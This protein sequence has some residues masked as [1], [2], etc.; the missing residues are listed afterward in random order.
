MSQHTLGDATK[1]RR[2]FVVGYDRPQDRFFCQ[3][4]SRKAFAPFHI[5]FDFDLDDLILM[6]ARVPEGLR[7]QL[8]K[9]VTGQADTNTCKDW[10]A[11]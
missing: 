2:R 6:G 7:D 8:A 1:K 11:A 9:E 5:D 3:V 4:Y 10:R